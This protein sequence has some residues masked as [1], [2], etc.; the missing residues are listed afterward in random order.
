MKYGIDYRLLAK[1]DPKGPPV[2]VT[3]GSRFAYE[4]DLVLLAGAPYVAWYEKTR[5]GDLTAW[6][7]RLDA[8]GRAVWR[9]RLDGA[10]GQARNPVLRVVA[11]GLELTLEPGRAGLSPEQVRAF[12]RTVTQAF[13]QLK[14]SEK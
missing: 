7:A 4:P 1:G 5:A 6:L 3:D 12:F 9:R 8:K 13:Q 14:E 2:T 10:G 11:D